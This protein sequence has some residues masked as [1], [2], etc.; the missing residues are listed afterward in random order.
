MR[1]TALETFPKTG[2][3]TLT[4]RK[5]TANLDFTLSYKPNN[6]VLLQVCKS[7]GKEKSNLKN[8]GL[9]DSGRTFILRDAGILLMERGSFGVLMLKLQKIVLT[10]QGVAYVVKRNVASSNKAQA[11]V[12]YY[13]PVNTKKQA[14]KGQAKSP[15]SAHLTYTLTSF[16]NC[17]ARRTV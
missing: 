6:V 17:K 2:K 13:G 4:K 9:L 15:D 10:Y 3:S 8:W 7:T 5:K 11:S 14:E 1:L 16:H 12:T